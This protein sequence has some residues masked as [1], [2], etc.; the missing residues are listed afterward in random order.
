[1]AELGDPVGTELGYEHPVVIVS[2]PELI[3]SN[4]TRVICVPGTSK[5]YINRRTGKPLK[6]HLEVAQNLKNGLSRPTY[7]M[8]EQV[9]V[10]SRM[11][12][13]RRMGIIDQ[14]LLALLEEHL[15]FAM[16]L[17]EPV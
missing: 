16:D 8:S 9:R 12:F 14:S 15:R 2:R 13:K 4:S 17:F 10:L 11:R 1:M 5:R 6:L 3:V 7:F